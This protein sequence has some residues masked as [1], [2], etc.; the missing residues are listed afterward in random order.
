MRYFQLDPV[1]ARRRV[2]RTLLWF[3]ALA[4]LVIIVPLWRSETGRT[5]GQ[6][7]YLDLLP[8]LLVSAVM[9]AVGRRYMLRMWL[10]RYRVGLREEMVVLEHPVHGTVRMARGDVVSIYEGRL[11]LVV[12]SREVG[13]LIDR[14]IVG[15][16]DV[17]AQLEQWAAIEVAQPR[18]TWRVVAHLCCV[19]LCGAAMLVALGSVDPIVVTVSAGLYMALLGGSVIRLWRVQ[20]ESFQ[21][22]PWYWAMVLLPTSAVVVKVVLVLTGRIPAA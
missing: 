17:R 10:E 9:L 22:N 4:S 14:H 6:I 12:G 3:L 16:A 20:R 2:R 11:G 18:W 13:L 7:A 21:P 5:P 1:I 19:L 8:F 15:Y